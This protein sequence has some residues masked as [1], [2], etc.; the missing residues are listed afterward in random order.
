MNVTGLKTATFGTGCFWCTEAVFQELNGV[1]KVTSGY[2]GGTVANPSYEEVC[3]GTT[4]HAE[5][6]QIEYDPSIVTFDELLQVFF[7]S[8]DPTQLN[9]QGNDVGTQYRSAIFF[10]DAEQKEKAE[11]YIAQLNQEGAYP[12]P[13]VTEVTPASIFY[14]AEDYHQNYYNT[15]G[16]QPY[17]YLVIR[18][19]VE[20]FEKVF[21]DKLKKNAAQK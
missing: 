19:K 17:C 9:R 12:K 5:C 13:I 1:I 3:T 6:L 11:H 4:G 21:K 16:S 7:S 2:M 8:H 10:H 15:H 18:P 14:G 20:K